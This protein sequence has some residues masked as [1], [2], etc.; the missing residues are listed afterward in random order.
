MVRNIY[1]LTILTIITIVKILVIAAIASN[2]LLLPQILLIVAYNFGFLRLGTGAFW[3]VATG[4]AVEAGATGG[5][6][7]PSCC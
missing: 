7:G 2:A 6:V 3:G 5:G 1:I 4:G